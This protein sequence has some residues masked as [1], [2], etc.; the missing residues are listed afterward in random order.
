MAVIIGGS[1]GLGKG[2]AQGFV[3]AGAK[4]IIASRNVKELEVAKS[5]IKG[6]T[7]GSCFAMQLDITSVEAISKFVNKMELF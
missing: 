6:E 7:K 4:I 5:E 3:K 2:I 1:K